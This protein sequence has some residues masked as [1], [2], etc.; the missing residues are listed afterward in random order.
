MR[1]LWIIVA[2]GLVGCSPT[3]GELPI[4]PIVG[5]DDDDGPAPGPK[6]TLFDLD[7]TELPSAV[8]GADYEGRVLVEGY[9]G[10]AVFTIA[11][12]TLP[13]GL[14]MADDGEVSG[15]ATALGTW[16]LWIRA[17]E[18]TIEDAFGCVQLRVTDLPKD[19][20][21]GY[22]HDQRTYLTDNEGVQQDLWLRIAQ[23]GEERWR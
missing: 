6:C 13:P 1:G 9:D 22:V 12:G 5:D 10:P 17:R 20:F 11:Q 8:E 15:R 7:D 18:M 21:L 19:A 3:A 14:T 4:E 16:D 2:L 23:G